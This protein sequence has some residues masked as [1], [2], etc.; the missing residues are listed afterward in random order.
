VDLRG[1]LSTAAITPRLTITRQG[2]QVSV[3]WAPADGQLQAASSLNGPVVNWQ[4][5]A[6]ATNPQTLDASTGMRF[7][8]VVQ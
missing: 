4:T 7:F 5:I 8:R 2:N 1:V 3:S 6:N